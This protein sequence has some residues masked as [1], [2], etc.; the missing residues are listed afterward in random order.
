MANST[1]SLSLSAKD[2]A[3]CPPSHLQCLLLQCPL[4]L[5][6]ALLVGIP[7]CSLCRPH[8]AG[9]LTALTLGCL[10]LLP[11]LLQLSHLGSC[12][13]PHC[14]HLFAGDVWSCK[15]QLWHS[16]IT[17]SKGTGFPSWCCSKQT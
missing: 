4:P 10:P 15:P 13:T 8:P 14:R 16:S 12:F 9:S 17:G 2:Y 5:L 7:Q 6:Q 3:T 11:Q 1:V